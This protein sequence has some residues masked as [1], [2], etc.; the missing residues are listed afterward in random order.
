VITT[1]ISGTPS[2]GSNAVAIA[3]DM[4]TLFASRH[5]RRSKVFIAMN[6]NDVKHMPQIAT[7]GQQAFPGVTISG[8]GIVGATIVPTEH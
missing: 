1:G 3:Q 8:G 5:W 2:S 7:T 4:A 6:P